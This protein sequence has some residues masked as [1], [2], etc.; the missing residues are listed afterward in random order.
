MKT[1]RFVFSLVISIFLADLLMAQQ[2]TTVPG[3]LSQPH[4]RAHLGGLDQ[5]WYRYWDKNYLITYGTDGSYE[6]SPTKPSIVLYDQDGQIVREAIVWFKDAYS[7]GINDVAINKVGGVALSG[8]TESESGVVANFIALIG[9]DNHISRL[10]RTTPFVPIY[11]CLEE[12]GTVWTYGFD[13][14]AEGKLV[15]GTSMLRHYSFDSG[16]L[17]A[18]LDRSSLDPKGWRLPEGRYPGEITLR[19]TSKQLG[20]FNAV[21]NE[22]IQLNLATN[23]LKV[24]KVAALPPPKEMRITG[25]AL[26]ESGEVFLSLHDRVS[27]PNPVRNI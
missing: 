14:D 4:R 12:D 19:C 26:T 2:E 21:S 25:F 23:A 22:W 13:R 8:G 18:M 27:T 5:T 3:M 1:A 24:S 6:A 10:V 17:G 9:N 15:E 7:I 16:Q 20:L 11:L